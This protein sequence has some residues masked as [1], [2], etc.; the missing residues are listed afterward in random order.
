MIERVAKALKPWLVDGGLADD[1]NATQAARDVL[2]AMKVPTVEMVI[3]G[4]EDWLCIRAMEDRA[5]VIWD[6]MLDAAITPSE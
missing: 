2:E 5:E 4:T 1:R 3:A 6:A